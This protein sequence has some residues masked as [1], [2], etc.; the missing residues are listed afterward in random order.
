MISS[1]ALWILAMAF[2]LLHV[3]INLNS[4][5]FFVLAALGCGLIPLTRMK[6]FNYFILEFLVV[7]ISMALSFPEPPHRQILAEVLSMP[8]WLYS[9]IVAILSS[10]LFAFL[11]YSVYRWIT[12]PYVFD[13]FGIELARS[14]S[15]E[16]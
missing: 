3:Q 11:A 8:F 12:L 1:R 13:F 4:D 14:N 5:L 2:V 15:D 16:T 6:W 9:V 10:V 7:I